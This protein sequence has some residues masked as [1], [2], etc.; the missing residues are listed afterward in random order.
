MRADYTKL[1][2]V[3]AQAVRQ[4]PKALESDEVSGVREVKVLYRDGT[5]RVVRLSER[6]LKS[7]LQDPEVK[8]VEAPKRMRLQEGR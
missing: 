3:L 2:P 8:Y 6:N 7:L 4:D 5:V 1:D